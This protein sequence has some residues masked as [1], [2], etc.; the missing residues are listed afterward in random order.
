M[1]RPA[2]Q[3]AGL[4]PGGCLPT[5]VGSDVFFVGQGRSPKAAKAICATCPVI[6]GC[7]A[8]ALGQRHLSGIWGGMTPP[9]LAAERKRRRAAAQSA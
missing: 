6:A 4:A 8:W 1:G 5:N 2:S 9:E 3:P 7:R